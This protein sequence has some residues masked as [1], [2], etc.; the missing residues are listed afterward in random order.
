MRIV[1]IFFDLTVEFLNLDTCEKRLS[2]LHVKFGTKNCMFAVASAK[3]QLF[4]GG[5]WYFYLLFCKIKVCTHVVISAEGWKFGQVT[6][7]SWGS[8]WWVGD[9]G[10]EVWSA[11]CKNKIFSDCFWLIKPLTFLR[12]IFLSKYHKQLP[13]N[14]HTKC[15]SANCLWIFYSALVGRKADF[16]C[17]IW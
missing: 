8:S 6:R 9:G 11:W 16:A 1:L 13:R 10:G 5:N 12:L 2:I 4:R 17:E 14:A 15:A 3:F 7:N